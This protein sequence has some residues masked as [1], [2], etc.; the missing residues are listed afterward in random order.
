MTRL[1]AGERRILNRIELK[2]GILTPV[3]LFLVLVMATSAAIGVVSTFGTST[4]GTNAGGTVILPANTTF[5]VSSSYDSVAG[6]YLLNFSM[7]DQSTLTGGFIAERP[8]VTMFVATTQQ[9]ATMYEGHPANWAYS[10]GLLNSSRFSLLLSPGSYVVWI[11]GADM[12]CG[13]GVSTPLEQ[14]TQVNVTE[15]FTLTSQSEGGLQLRLALSWNGQFIVSGSTLGISVNE[16]NPSSSAINVSRETN[17]PLSG[18]STG[19]CPSLYYPFGIAVFQGKY[20]GANLSQAVPLRIFPVVPCP[21]IV[22]Y[23][24]GYEFQPMSDNATVLPG[25]GEVP[26]RTEVFVNGTYNANGGLQNGTTPFLPGIYTVVAGDEWGNLAL[27]YLVVEP[28]NG[29]PVFAYPTSNL[30]SSISATVDGTFIVQLS[31]NA[32]STGFD[33]NVSTSAGIQYLNYTVVSTSPLIGGPQVRDYFFRAVQTGSE[34]I[35][36]RD[37]RPFAPHAV[38]ATIDLQVDVT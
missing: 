21:L 14:Q 9:E 18:L 15:A 3:V 6:H 12:N 31:S 20:T 35:T 26:M 23:I 16:F 29:V 24:T 22:R 2:S 36:L 27:D 10:T 13:S 7:S 1:K 17:W 4:K 8:G 33:W 38:V 11:E 30:T 34:T 19:M 32:G 28:W 37:E 25:T 5:E